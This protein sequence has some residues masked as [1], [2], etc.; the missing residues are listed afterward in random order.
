MCLKH[1]QHTFCKEWGGR[2]CFFEHELPKYAS[3][4]VQ[5][6]QH[7]QEQQNNDNNN[8]DISVSIFSTQT[9]MSSC[10]SVI[11]PAVGNG[12]IACVITPKGGNTKEMFI[13]LWKRIKGATL[14]FIEEISVCNCLI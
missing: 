8:A 7:S 6:Q 4:H 10:D 14:F 13:L 12:T 1:D 3:M 9:C 5:L 11:S 2:N